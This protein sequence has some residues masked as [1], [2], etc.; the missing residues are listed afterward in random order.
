MIMIGV[1]TKFIY[2]NLANATSLLGVLPLVILFLDNG[3]LY[4]IP[5]I[6]YNN[7]MDDLDGVLAAKL[8]I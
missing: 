4:V 1:V 8:N 3:Y 5:L 2:R 6:I 7:F